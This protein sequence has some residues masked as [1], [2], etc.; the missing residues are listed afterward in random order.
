MFHLH[1][2]QRIISLKLTVNTDVLLKLKHTSTHMILH[3]NDSG[4]T[5]LS[6]IKFLTAKIN[7]YAL[8]KIKIKYL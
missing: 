7:A 3:A 8:R 4:W 6:N 1:I 5:N 2:I